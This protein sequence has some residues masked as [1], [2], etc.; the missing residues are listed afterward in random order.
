QLI[1]VIEPSGQRGQVGPDRLVGRSRDDAGVVPGDRLHE[2]RPDGRCRHPGHL[3]ERLAQTAVARNAPTKDIAG[4]WLQ[5][6][7][8]PALGLFDGGS[9]LGIGWKERRIGLQLLERPG[10]LKRALDLAAVD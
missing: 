1:D 9:L 8:A 10:D 6:R 3:T 7:L 5:D 2:D 4:Y